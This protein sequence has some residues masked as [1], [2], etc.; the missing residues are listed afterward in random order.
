MRLPFSA[1]FGLLILLLVLA[2]VHVFRW[3]AQAFALSRLSRRLLTAV[4]AASL[5]GMI[6]GRAADRIW[7]DAPV[8]ALLLASSTVQL[9]V[10]VSVVF[11][12]AGDLLLLAR[13]V[14]VAAR[15]AIS[16][17]RA[18]SP[19][20]DLPS[21]S[22]SSPAPPSPAPELARRTFLGQAAA[23]SA[24]LIGSSSSLYG[25][26]SGRHDYAIDEVPVRIPGLSLGLDGFSIVQL[27]DVHIGQFVGEAEL[28]AAVDLVRS[29]RPDLIVLTGDLLDHDARLAHR[30]GSFVRRLEPL[31]REG[32]VAISGNH[33]FYAGVAPMVSACEGG[34]ARV[35]RNRGV[36]IGDATSGFALLGVDD[37]A[38]G[39]RARGAG[40]DLA[41][42]IDSLPLLG[43]KVAPAR[44]LPR[45]LLC[46]NPSF[47]PVAAP[48][49]AL[50]LSGH[51]HGGQ[52][53]LLVRPADWVLPH[54]YVAGLYERSGAR[55][56][57]NRGFG[58][59]GPPARIGA[60]PEITRIVLA[61][62]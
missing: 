62:G 54:G 57:V 26:L 7:S 18:P 8:R 60:P 28:A 32:V 40:P 29:A 37:V 5:V 30:L 31:A 23:G 47:F 4:L 61:A 21:R 9:A 50:Q 39:R 17:V 49:V 25:A 33:D 51:T 16:R 38:A 55:L 44:D 43:G 46:H 1:F 27:S 48:K 58:T 6:V 22:G 53:N 19:K 59:V 45:V 15:R 3:A 36:V 11:L 41:K 56:Y 10:L 14:A 12:L 2:N 24:F 13:R 42:A 52:V 34:G 20:P 35:L